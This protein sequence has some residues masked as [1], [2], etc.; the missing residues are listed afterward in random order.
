MISN[1]IYPVVPFFLYFGIFRG[2]RRSFVIRTTVIVV[3]IVIPIIFVICG[4]CFICIRAGIIAAPISIRAVLVISTAITGTISIRIRDLPGSVAVDNDICI[5]SIIRQIIDPAI[6]TASSILCTGELIVISTGIATVHANGYSCR[7]TILQIFLEEIVRLVCIFL[8]VVLLI[9]LIFFPEFTVIAVIIR[10]MLY[11]ILVIGKN[12]LIILKLTV[13]IFWL[14]IHP[15]LV[16]NCHRYRTCR[17][18]R[19]SSDRHTRFF[20]SIFHLLYPLFSC[21]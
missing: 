3:G 2:C 15:A 19:S 7:T 16:G 6:L 10:G 18:H 4:R 13:G 5:G 12:D 9:I 8:I 14:K 11:L 1:T 17:D 20:I 21:A